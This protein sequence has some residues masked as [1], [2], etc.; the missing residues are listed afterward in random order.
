MII[1]GNIVDI[2]NR[3]IFKG[4]IEVSDGKIIDIRPSEHD[5][6]NY[7]LPGFIDAHGHLKGI[8][9]RELSLNLQEIPSLNKTSPL[10]PRDNAA[11]SPDAF[12]YIIFP[13]ANP[14]NLSKVT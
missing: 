9:Y 1:K 2:L 11:G 13:L 5:V 3:S 10:L 12:P 8:G 6:K 7:I 4:E 14:A